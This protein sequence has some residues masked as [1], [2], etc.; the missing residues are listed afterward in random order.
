LV[1]EGSSDVNLDS[2]VIGRMKHFAQ[3]N[4]LKKMCLMV[5]GQ[6]LSVE[7]ITGVFSDMMLVLSAS[8]SVLVLI[9]LPLLDRAQGALQEH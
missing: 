5:V 2:V 7:E 6:H 9:L 3:A 4:K 8:S 1:K